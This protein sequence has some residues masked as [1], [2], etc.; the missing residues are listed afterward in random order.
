MDKWKAKYFKYI[1]VDPKEEGRT[2]T[3]SLL[4]P[5]QSVVWEQ[6]PDVFHL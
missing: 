6:I 4:L 1:N 2:L 5:Q 3:P